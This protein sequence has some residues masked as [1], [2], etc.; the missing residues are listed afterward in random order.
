MRIRVSQLFPVLLMLGVA[1]ATFWLEQLVQ[2]PPVALTDRARH[3]P[4]F[5]IENFTVTRMNATGIPVSSLTADKM[6]H[7]PD[8]ESTD[9]EGPRF[10][11]T[12]PDQPPVAATALRGSVSKDGETVVMRDNVIVIR[13]GVGNRPPSKMETTELIVKPESEIA[14]TDAKVVITEGTSRLE[15]TG[16]QVNS[17]TRE[18]ELHSRVRAT[19]LPEAK[20]DSKVNSKS[21]KP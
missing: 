21:K 15:G 10:T 17:K 14:R 11:Q 13:G 16:M 9:L 4:D 5:V 18:F 8:D 3:D 7:Y 1:L 20:G 6:L 19:Y 12:N 2:L